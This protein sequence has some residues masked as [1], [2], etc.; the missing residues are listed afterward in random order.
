MCTEGLW[1]LASFILVILISLPRLIPSLFNFY[2]VLPA[3]H[4]LKVCLWHRLLG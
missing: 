1:Q 4:L 2:V 3:S